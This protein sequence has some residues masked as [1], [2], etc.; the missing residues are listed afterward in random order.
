MKDLQLTQ[1]ALVGARITDF[2]DF[3]YTDR[4]AMAMR[5]VA[6]ELEPTVEQADVSDEA[7]KVSRLRNRLP[8][9][10]HNIINDPEFPSREELLM[11]LRRFEGELH[12]SR[13][14]EVV[15]AVLSHG[16]KNESFD[17]LNLP[18]TMPLSQRCAMVVHIDVWESAFRRLEADLYKIMARNYDHIVSWCKYAQQDD[19]ASIE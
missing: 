8:V 2:N 9:W 18:H 17:P 10:V 13:N 4:N 11:P 14:N 19:H 6:P 15:S 1:I 5:R 3:G 12:D 16:F 7:M